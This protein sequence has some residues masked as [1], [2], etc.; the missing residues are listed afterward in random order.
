MAA[1]T[2]WNPSDKS[3]NIGLT[4]GNLTATSTGAGAI[5]A[6]NYISGTD[7]VFFSVTYDGNQ[8]AIG[9]GDSTASLS[10]QPGSDTTHSIAYR[11][12]SASG[13]VYYNGSSVATIGQATAGDVIYCC[14]DF[15][16]GKIWFARN[17]GNYNNSGTANPATNTGGITISV[18]GKLY[19]LWYAAATGT[20]TTANFGASG[21]YRAAPSGFTSV[22]D[23]SVTTATTAT[24]GSV[25]VASDAASATA[26]M[27]AWGGGG[28]TFSGSAQAA[29]GEGGGYAQTNAVSC[30]ASAVIYYSVGAGG[31]ANNSSQSNGTDSWIQSGTNSAPSSTT[32]GVLA[33]GGVGAS[34]RGTAGAVRTTTGQVG[35]VTQ[36]GG[37]GADAQGGGGSRGG[38]SG[39]NSGAPAANGNPG[40]AGSGAS[41][42]TRPTAQTGSGQ[43]ALGGAGAG[44]AAGAAGTPGGGGGGGGSTSGVGTAGGIGQITLTLST[45]YA[46]TVTANPKRYWVGGSGNTNDTAHWS[47]TSGGASG[48]TLPNSSYDAIFDAS[49]DS[50]AGFTVTVNASFDCAS[51]DNTAVDQVMTLAGSSALNIYGSLA[52]KST[53]VR[54]YGATITFKAIAT[55][56]TITT[57]GVSLATSGG[58]DF[59]GVGGGW[60]LGSA[61]TIYGGTLSAGALDT[62]GYNFTA[63]TVPFYISGSTTRSLTLGASVVTVDTWT[64]TSTTNFTFSAGT[65]LIKNTSNNFFSGGGLTYY[66]VELPSGNGVTSGI[67]GANTFHN[68]TFK[69][70]DSAL[71]VSPTWIRLSANQIVNGTFTPSQTTNVNARVIVVS[72]ALDAQRTITAAA[73]SLANVDFQNIV[74]AGAA[75]WTGT[76]VGNGGNNSGITFTAAKTVYAVGTTSWSWTANKWATSS[77]GSVSFANFPLPQDTVIIDN[78]S[79]STSATITATD[80]YL[81]PAIDC[82]A[83]SN[84]MTLNLT[85]LGETRLL[86]I[87]SAITLSGLIFSLATNQTFNQNG[88]TISGS[89][90]INNPSTTLTLTGN[91]TTSSSTTLTNGTLNLAGYTLT[92]DTFA[93]A[94]G[95]KNLTA[96][97]GS[98]VVTGSGA[99]AFNNAQPTNFTTTA[100]SGNGVISLTSAS[101]KTFV[102]GGS[103]YAFALNQGGAGALTVTGS[104]TLAGATNTT[105]PASILF[106]AGTTTTFTVAPTWAGT[107]GNLITIG[108]VTSAQHTLS[109]ASGTVDVS[110]CNISYSNATG[111]ASWLAYA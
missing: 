88:A 27:Q 110:Y 16:N 77:N 26:L 2:T 105:Q 1:G 65:S 58:V 41:G 70:S 22:P 44:G 66:D 63:T 48:A 4:G 18:T 75:S 60:T 67:N 54:T 62:A 87:N 91:L 81:Y 95:T 84:A 78:S 39:G 50:G 92:T 7:K 52:L 6:T 11:P 55:G 107:S 25:T 104:N 111:G 23:I 85:G 57:N 73:V 21:F 29:S 49:S 12:Q 5:R 97:G 9:V 33:K 24:T 98:L 53:T 61:L 17:A 90:N 35:N 42:G 14:I 38:S 100:G 93:T 3:A 46:I 30:A 102:G 109:K 43:G 59:N 89:V 64:V 74:G 45:Y 71:A 19:P 36:S 32:G 86:T 103:T 96:N 40:I 56:K 15:A 28:G 106:T 34:A 69:G 72:D 68:L 51:L 13:D 76:S 101:A 80:N 31:L 108:S 10:T 99:T 8:S 47:E 83:R 82:S 94:T 79:V 37:A 20:A